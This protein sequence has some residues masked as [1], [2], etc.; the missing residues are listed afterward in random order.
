MVCIN[1]KRPLKLSVAV[2]HIVATEDLVTSVSVEIIGERKMA[3]IV[4]GELPLEIQIAVVYP[5]TGVSILYQD[6]RRSFVSGDIDYANCIHIQPLEGIFAELKACNR[7]LGCREFRCGNALS[8]LS[9]SSV[10]NHQTEIPGSDYF[11]NSVP[12]YV[13]DLER[14]IRGK[15]FHFLAVAGLSYLP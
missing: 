1:G 4:L 11:I 10:Q 8:D 6:V 5:Q 7:L 15:F 9:R 14:K 12:V 2:N 3:G 13:V